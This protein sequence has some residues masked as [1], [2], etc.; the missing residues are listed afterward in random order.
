MNYK[1][2]MDIKDLLDNCDLVVREKSVPKGKVIPPH[3][4]NY[5]ELEIITGGRAVQVYN[6]E[7]YQLCRGSMYMLSYCDYHSFSATD[8]LSL[9][10]IRFKESLLNNSIA[11]H[12]NI[13]PNRLIHNFNESEINEIIS[14][15][16]VLDKETSN[17]YGYNKIKHNF[18]AGCFAYTKLVRYGRRER[19]SA[20]SAG[21]CVCQYKLQGKADAW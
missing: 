21:G 18:R 12:I 7:K 2:L 9:I 16:K 15:I 20:D 17:I 6:G 8:E 19:A 3:W 10:S 11:K 1:M 14:K 5:L 13:K 4:H